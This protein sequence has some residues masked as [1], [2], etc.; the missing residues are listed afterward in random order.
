MTSGLK[1]ENASPHW[2]ARCR[3]ESYLVT[4]LFPIMTFASSTSFTISGYVPEQTT[5]SFTDKEA[6]IQSNYTGYT[7]T[8]TYL[9]GSTLV[10]DSTSLDLAGVQKIT[11]TSP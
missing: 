2:I 7:I 10:T 8:I 4:L 11:I 6:L 3:F 5:V 9:D 1:G